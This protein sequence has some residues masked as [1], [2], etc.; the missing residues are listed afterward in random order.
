MQFSITTAALEH[1]CYR[2]DNNNFT[3]CCERR[4]VALRHM[5][6]LRLFVITAHN[7]DSEACAACGWMFDSAWS[8][9]FWCWWEVRIVASA[10][11]AVRWKQL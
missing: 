11:A 9:L 5:S 7:N 6:L 1:Q 4:S 2:L 3:N 10:A 8:S